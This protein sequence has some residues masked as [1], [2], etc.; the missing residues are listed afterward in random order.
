MRVSCLTCLV[1]LL[2]PLVAK[3]SELCSTVLHA[4]GSI[5]CSLTKYVSYCPT[6]SWHINGIVRANEDS[7]N[8]TLMKSQGPRYSTFYSCHQNISYRNICT[9]EI[10]DCFSTCPTD[11]DFTTVL[12]PKGYSAPD[13]VS[14]AAIIG[15]SV[16]GV[17]V[18]SVFL[19]V[20]WKRKLLKRYFQASRNA[21]CRCGYRATP[22]DAEQ[23]DQTT[24]C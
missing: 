19:L 13:G 18:L 6:Y 23:H 17:V 10:I 4:N 5:T 3:A 15:G 7:F 20:C 9:G 1:H 2:W 12:Q 24:R 21:G 8:S 22:Q 14:L 11:S 16:G